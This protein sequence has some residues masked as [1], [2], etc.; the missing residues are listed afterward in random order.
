M[1]ML[2]VDQVSFKIAIHLFG[3]F[4]S[5]HQLVR[6]L[7]CATVYL[8]EGEEQAKVDCEWYGSQSSQRLSSTGGQCLAQVTAGRGLWVRS[9]PSTTYSRVQ[10]LSNGQQVTVIGR[11]RGWLQLSNGYVFASYMRIVRSNGQGCCST[12]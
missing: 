1:T 2:P 12:G 6:Y 9:D 5:R 11:T 8:S 3:R 7:I 10:S 4:S